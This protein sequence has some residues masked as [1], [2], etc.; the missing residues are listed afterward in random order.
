M[1]TFRG[2]S[3]EIVRVSVSYMQ[4]ISAKLAVC[5]TQ[6]EGR[7]PRCVAMDAHAVWSG[8]R[9]ECL[10][11]LLREPPVLRVPSEEVE[12]RVLDD[13]P[14]VRPV[15][16]EARPLIERERW[17]VGRQVTIGAVEHVGAQSG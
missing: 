1:I 15:R 10:G 9:L 11:R 7:V 6:Y 16:E 13:A 5:L 3:S 2:R 12:R 4:P 14:D 17:D 8:C